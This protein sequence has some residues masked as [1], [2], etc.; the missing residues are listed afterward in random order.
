MNENKNNIKVEGE[1][2]KFGDA[3]RYNKSKG[4]F[5]LIPLDVFQR[6]TEYAN[7][8][9]RVENDDT[10]TMFD[11]VNK[12]NGGISRGDYIA[13]LYNL[14]IIP[15]IHV[16]IHISRKEY[17]CNILPTMM[18]HLALHF[19]HGAE[20][21]G[22]RNCEKGIPLWSFIDSGMRHWNQYLL[23]RTDEDHYIAAVWN[24]WM[25]KWTEINH[26]ERCGPDG[27]DNF[28]TSHDNDV[29]T[30]HSSC[31]D[32]TDIKEPTVVLDFNVYNELLI[33]S[34]KT[35]LNNII[36]EYKAIFD[37]SIP[38]VESS[39]N[40]Y[41]RIFDA[42]RGYFVDTMPFSKFYEIYRSH[43]IYRL[44]KSTP[45][46][47]CLYVDSKGN[48]AY[49]MFVHKT[50][51]ALHVVF[52]QNVTLCDFPNADIQTIFNASTIL[53]VMDAI[54]LAIY[55]YKTRKVPINIFVNTSK[56]CLSLRHLYLDLFGSYILKEFDFDT[57]CIWKQIVNSSDFGTKPIT[58]II[59]QVLEKG[60][61]N[62]VIDG[63]DRYKV[64]CVMMKD[65]I[66]E[67]MIVDID[68][69]KTKMSE[70]YDVFDSN[71]NI[72]HF[73]VSVIRY[74]A[75]VVEQLT[76]EMINIY[77]KR[78]HY[79][80][81]A[82]KTDKT[83]LKNN[84]HL[85][86][87]TFDEYCSCRFPIKQSV[88]RPNI[89]MLDGKVVY[90]YPNPKDIIKDNKRIIDKFKSIN[91][92]ISECYSDAEVI[93]M[94]KSVDKLQLPN[95]VKLNKIFNDMRSSKLGIC[96]LNNDYDFTAQMSIGEFM[97]QSATGV[98]NQTIPRFVD[99]IDFYNKHHTTVG[100]SGTA[101]S[102]NSIVY[103]LSMDTIQNKG[104]IKFTPCSKVYLNKVV[105]VYTYIYNLMINGEIDIK[106]IKRNK[107]KNVWCF[108]SEHEKEI[109]EMVELKLR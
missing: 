90:V 21:Y 78:F 2:H 26:P 47:K 85:M 106:W 92:Y 30:K 95:S 76:D 3:V 84:R 83:K 93:K 104:V 12:I 24:F 35:E 64:S 20:K 108:Y 27:G 33:A 54:G 6:L 11:I 74:P 58:E 98:L 40:L 49:E 36:K 71:D 66:D 69:Y 94:Y 70:I 61:L 25:A 100:I 8:I 73:P 109:K 103:R 13:T 52:S 18:L 53:S 63:I 97:I 45:L 46:L 50:L 79:F 34:E 39:H 38:K 44:P 22:P 82:F 96:L 48:D 77:T 41:D 1:F 60:D 88:I 17:F 99:V 67:T 72:Y 102:I 23:G 101:S 31:C 9:H 62:V 57:K 43:H 91:D 29:T 65:K 4:R 37:V 51:E 7:N 28:K 32:K 19:Q 59:K 107:C 86:N 15:H 75:A 81:N 80:K 5:D 16:P 105:Q 55:T 10:I 56:R 68:P 42:F 89:E 14:A 87:Q